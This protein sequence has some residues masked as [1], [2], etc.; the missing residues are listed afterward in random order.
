MTFKQMLDEQFKNLETLY[1]ERIFKMYQD[2][3]YN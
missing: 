2:I 1:G 3:K